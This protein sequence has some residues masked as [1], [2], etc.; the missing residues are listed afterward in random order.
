MAAEGTYWQAWSRRAVVT[1]LVALGRRLVALT[2]ATTRVCLRYR[3]TGLAAEAGFFALLSLPPL[4]LGLVATAG[5]VGHQMGI[6]VMTDLRDRIAEVASG[7]VTPGVVSSVI[8]PTF[9]DLT[10]GDRLDIVSIGF[11]LSLWSGSRALNV[12]VDT[13]S[14]MYGQGGRRGIVQTRV[15]SFSLYVGALVVGMVLIPLIL[16]GPSLLSQLLHD[17]ISGLP[18]LAW[19]NWLYWPLVTV[20]SVAGLTTLYHVAT[21]VRRSWWRDLP[22]A[23][24]ALVIWLL[25][26]V[27]LRL[28]LTASVD[29]T[30][31]YGPLAAP[32]VLLIWS[33]A[34]ALAALI[35]AALNAALNA[36]T[37]ATD[38]DDA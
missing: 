29:G 37:V 18:S 15:L 32:I 13:V 16:V 36:A 10:R 23:A 35:G 34:F 4:V 2:V 38:A 1:Q 30:S 31:I 11:L 25:A 9:E 3:V 7:F 17:W 20:V 33:Y 24:L 26:S 22:G 19:L 8:V 28:V 5:S 27:V 14:I 12:Y 21:P 6:Q